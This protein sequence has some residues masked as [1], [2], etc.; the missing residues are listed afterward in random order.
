MKALMRDY[1]WYY[2]ISETSL[3]SFW[4]NF[5]I[6]ISNTVFTFLKTTY[7]VQIGSFE[8]SFALKNQAIQLENEKQD[9]AKAYK[10]L[11]F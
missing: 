7:F 1:L 5:V 10:M 9:F 3:V 8:Q 2:A 4:P 11:S 6:E